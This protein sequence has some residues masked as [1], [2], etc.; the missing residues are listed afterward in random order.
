KWLRL[1]PQRVLDLGTGTGRA[2][3]ALAARFPTAELIALDLTEDMLKVA[4]RREGASPLTVC[5]N[6][7]H[8]P[9]ADASVD[10]VF[11]SLMIH[12]CTSLDSLF[13]EVRRVLRYP[14][15]FS[16]ATLGP[17]S[18]RELRAAWQAVDDDAHVMRFPEMTALGNGLLRAGLAEPVIDV[19]T[20]TICYPDLRQLTTDLRSTGTT[21]PNSGRRQGLTGRRS[22][23]RLEA[24][25]G[26]QRDA[27]GALPVTL[28]MVFG[29]AWAKPPAGSGSQLRDGPS[30]R[31]I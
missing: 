5:G 17:G 4:A 14:G 12:W 30:S 20:L 25:Y 11:S 24:A 6:A 9:L 13:A 16:F 21:N 8:L 7:S 26:E 18:F 28:E 19:E 10:M 27:N 22:W 15:V 31:S 1:E 23:A 29:A 2:L 3:P